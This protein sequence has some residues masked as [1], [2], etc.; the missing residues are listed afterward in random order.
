MEFA[1]GADLETETEVDPIAEAFQEEKAPR[2]FDKS[3]IRRIAKQQSNAHV[4]KQIALEYQRLKGDPA[5]K[6]DMTNKEA[7][8]LGDAFK[9]MWAAQNPNLVNVT[10]DENNQKYLEL[11]PEGEDVLADGQSTRKRLFP[12]ANVKPAKNPPPKGCLLY[13][14]PSPRDS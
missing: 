8:T 4:G 11:T 10:R 12:S 6:N 2:E 7:E 1:G 9:M 5:P 3:K 13:T 14:S